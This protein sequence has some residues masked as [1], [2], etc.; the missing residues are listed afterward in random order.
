M[1]I[2][3]QTSDGLKFSTTYMYVK[4][5][6]GTTLAAISSGGNLGIGTNNPAQKLHV[7]G[8][9]IRVNQGTSAVAMGEYSNCAVIWLDGANGD[10]AG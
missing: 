4:N 9:Q 3:T 5:S 2:A 7:N 6:S 1:G 10:F 8:G